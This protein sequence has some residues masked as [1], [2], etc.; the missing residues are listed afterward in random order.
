MNKTTLIKFSFVFVA[1]ATVLLAGVPQSAIAKETATVPIIRSTSDSSLTKPKDTSTTPIVAVP[2]QADVT[3]RPGGE[4]DDTNVSITVTV[5]AAPATDTV[6][7]VEATH[8]DALSFPATVTVPAG[9]TTAT[10]IGTVVPGDFSHHKNV[11]IYVSANG[12]TVESKVRVHYVHE[13]D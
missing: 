1:T 3:A 13:Q 12:T 2:T 10:V 4:P 8:P 9:S 7:T 11:H 5:N 6:L